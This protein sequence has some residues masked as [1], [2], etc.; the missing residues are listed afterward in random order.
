MFV[1]GN[2]G[3]DYVTTGVFVEEVDQLFDSFNSNR[4][5]PHLRNCLAHLAMT[6]LIWF[7]G[8]RQAKG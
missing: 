4:V 2:F 8:T 1:L 6:V 5:H 3:A 7:T